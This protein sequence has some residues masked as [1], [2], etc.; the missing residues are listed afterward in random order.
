MWLNKLFNSKNKNKINIVRTKIV[1][2][3]FVVYKLFTYYFIWWVNLFNLT[4]NTGQSGLVISGQYLPA[5]IWHFRRTSGFKCFLVPRWIFVWRSRWHRSSGGRRSITF[6]YQSAFGHVAIITSR[7]SNKVSAHSGKPDERRYLFK[8][9]IKIYTTTEYRFWIN[10][11]RNPSAI[12]Q[13][14]IIDYF[15]RNGILSWEW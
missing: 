3:F 11:S 7:T 2:F 8:L 4:D 6:R 1:V 9:G 14:I 12:K 13:T 15:N 5:T 10:V